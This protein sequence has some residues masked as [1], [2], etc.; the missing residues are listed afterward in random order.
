M[1]YTSLP[2]KQGQAFPD[3]DMSAQ[4]VVRRWLGSNL[5]CP[6]SD[7]SLPCSLASLFLQEGPLEEHLTAAS[8]GMV[9]MPRITK[10]SAPTLWL[11]RLVVSSHGSKSQD[12]QKPEDQGA[13]REKSF[14]AYQSLNSSLII[15]TVSPDS[16]LGVILMLPHDSQTLRPIYPTWLS[17]RPLAHP[18]D[19]EDPTSPLTTSKLCSYPLWFP[20]LWCQGFI[21]LAESNASSPMLMIKYH[22]MISRNFSSLQQSHPF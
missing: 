18:L 19:W 3:S 14:G 20:L 5:L 11:W 17:K 13:Q 6:R 22:P 1:I 15:P 21:L 10:L 9:L 2:K 4:W 16:T 7:T 8:C 12:P